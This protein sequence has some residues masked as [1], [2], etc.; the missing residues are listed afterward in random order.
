MDNQTL[1]K[2]EILNII[3]NASFYDQI[4]LV[5]QNVQLKNS[6]EYSFSFEGDLPLKLQKEEKDISSKVFTHIHGKLGQEGVKMMQQ[7]WRVKA[8]ISVGDKFPSFD[9]TSLQGATSK[10]EPKS[11]EVYL[12]D[13]W[14]TWCGYCHEP[15]Q[16]NVDIVAKN[17]DFASKKI[18]IIGISCDQ[19]FQKWKSFVATKKWNTIPQY[20][21]SK[22]LQIAGIGGI[23]H[24][25]LVDKTGVCVWHGHP[26]SIDVEGS[27][28]NLAEGKAVIKRGKDEEDEEEEDQNPFWNE[29]DSETKK[30]FISDCSNIITS[31]GLNEIQFLVISKKTTNF[32][33][34]KQS[35]ENI[36][37]LSGFVSQSQVDSINIVFM[38]IQSTYNFKGI[39]PSIRMKQ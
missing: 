17:K 19:D 22:A 10:W 3:K 34:G 5:E 21:N 36:P 32:K 16:E 31:N 39:R 8:C 27:L 25:Y 24:V 7:I 23:P 37:I 18:N 6:T 2:D 35:V 33:T 4:K 30:T 12:V 14:A 1:L 28:K 38:E 9:I 13:L 20:N 26:A 15:M 11:G 29:I